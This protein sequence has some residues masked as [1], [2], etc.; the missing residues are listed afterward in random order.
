MWMG[1]F[2]NVGRCEQ[3][4]IS[5]MICGHVP[6]CAW[7][8]TYIDVLSHHQQTTPLATDWAPD[9]DNRSCGEPLLDGKPQMPH[10]R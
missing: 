9:K 3:F 6:F 10:K 7:P 5:T 8:S 2:Y 1:C 4:Q